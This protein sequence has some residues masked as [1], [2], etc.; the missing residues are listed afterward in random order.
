MTKVVPCDPENPPP[1]AA[2]LAAYV[3]SRTVS[4][5]AGFDVVLDEG[6]AEAMAGGGNGDGGDEKEVK[7]PFVVGL[8]PHSTLPMAAVLAFARFSPLGGRLPPALQGA[9]LLASNA[10]FAAPLV[11]HAWSWLGFAPASR[12]TMASLLA[13]G[14]I[15]N[16]NVKASPPAAP[17]SSSPRIKRGC[18]VVLCPGGIREVLH[19]RKDRETIFL[20]SRRGFVRQAL[21]AGAPLVPAFAFG[22]TTAFDWFP[23]L[24]SPP[25]PRALVSR[26]CRAIGFA[27]LWI[28]NGWLVPFPKRTAAMTL[29]IGKPLEFA[30]RRRGGGEVQS[31]T[32]AAAAA[33]EQQEEASTGAPPLPSATFEVFEKKSSK[34]SIKRRGLFRGL[35]GGKAGTSSNA[36]TSISSCSSSSSL[37][38]STSEAE[39]DAASADNN[40][41]SSSS[42]PLIQRPAFAF[43]EEDVD[44]YL[45]EF[46]EAMRD[47]Y[48][49]HAPALGSANV[50]L[51][52]L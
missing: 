13:T 37:S 42:I 11:R 36:A 24:P 25:L 45:A 35:R 47:L 49:R 12:R 48:E 33:A 16:G 39:T 10:C 30:P 28:H 50:P 22:Q 6:A 27:P 31:S 23:V 43:D 52:I 26:L 3:L 29:V 20:R 7:G 15:G 34:G 2:R 51:T 21:R 9:R 46:V 44:R 38:S 8:E 14:T 5:F 19:L 1:W 17:S 40:R 18:S 4:F 32:A 41:V